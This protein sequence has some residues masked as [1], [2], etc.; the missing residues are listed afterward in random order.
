MGWS[1]LFG[2]AIVAGQPGAD[3]SGE[4][5]DRPADRAAYQTVAAKAGP[6]AAGQVRLALWCEA[7]GMTAERMKHLALAVARDPSNALARGLLGL[8]NYEGKWERPEDVSRQAKDDP[9]Q[10]ALMEE[11]FRRRA[12]TAD[13]AED[14]W[15]LALWC[16]QKGL[17]SQ[18]IAHFH[19]VIRLDPRKE[20]AWRHLGFKQV[21]GRWI[22]PELQAAA[23]REAE[24]QTRANRHWRPQLERW[25]AGLASRDKGR[26]ATAEAGLAGVTEPR[27]VPMVWAVFAR[28]G[29]EGQKTAVRVLGQIDAPGS[30]RALALL[31]VSSKSVDVRGEAMRILRGRDPRD[32][33][34]LLVA[35]IHD[36]I[37]YHVQ[38]V[39]GPGKAGVLTIKDGSTNRKRV[40]KPLSEPN[41]M[42]GPNDRVSI[43]PATGLPV[44]SRLLG[45]EENPFVGPLT[46]PQELAYM[47][48]TRPGSGA[49]VAAL[50]SKAGLPAAQSQK[51][52]HVMAANAASSYQMQLNELSMLGDY[53]FGAPM[54][55]GVGRA[56]TLEIPIGQMELD[57]QRSA[58]VAR[59]QLAGDVQA[60]EAKNAQILQANR[61]VRQVLLQAVGIDK[62]DDRKAWTGWLVDLFGFALAAQQVPTNEST[63][64][65]QVP[66]S[67]QPQAAPVIE[68]GIGFYHHSCFGAGTPVRTLDGLRPI[69]TLR[70][71]DLV[72]TEDT[73][74]GELK[75]EA[76]VV[77]YH[78]PP[79]S[80][81]RIGLDG[82]E[83]IVATGIHRLWKSG[84]GWTMAREL[85]PGDTLRTLG[86]L[87][88]V[89]SVDAEKKQPVYNLQVA[90]GESY[91][92]GK[93]GVLAHD[94][95]TINP[96][97]E[98]FDAVAA[99]ADDS[100][101]AGRPRHSMLG[102]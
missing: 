46:L 26:Q 32:F 13:K 58:Q 83:S 34:P 94:N 65:E 89:E 75:Y 1:L 33:A 101:A 11:Y 78:N 31:A 74:T 92:V 17:K 63:V 70:A 18:A 69:E 56:E 35:M 102:R 60:I 2:L 20:G 53:M 73:H 24:E 90:E 87:A 49:Q 93:A 76:V 54:A 38:P 28:N 95:S 62:G 16:D 40:Y 84:K 79:N 42:L 36:P 91:F 51:L 6:D 45:V 85:K 27:A 82:G 43:D 12:R 100:A 30:S 81:L 97:L 44:I 64:I 23:R 41:V 55:V 99:T 48:V 22:K 77:V 98:P 52:G 96:V 3:A 50:L 59:M 72:L 68:E 86:G 25:R 14:Q 80:T 4:G 8:V 19:A 67:Y 39:A 5:G 7:H 57:A 21:G 10:R 47:G 37:K 61:P 71:G 88:R 9:K 15:K 66:L 29:V